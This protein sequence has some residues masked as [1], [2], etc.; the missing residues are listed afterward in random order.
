LGAE[1]A[2]SATLQSL[3]TYNCREK[4]KFIDVFTHLNQIMR[5]G[6][7]T[8]SAPLAQLLINYYFVGHVRLLVKKVFCE[9]N[10]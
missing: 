6:D 3:G 10:L 9:T 2:C 7:N 4:P 8:Q 1:G 5:A